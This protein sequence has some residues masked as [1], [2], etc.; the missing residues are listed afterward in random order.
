MMM[1]TVTNRPHPPPVDSAL[2]VVADVHH[3]HSLVGVHDVIQC[4]DWLMRVT[5]TSYKS[6]GLTYVISRAYG[7][8]LHD[9]GT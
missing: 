1:I 2:R 6:R 8:T 3:G 4:S 7:Y 5:I 9:Y